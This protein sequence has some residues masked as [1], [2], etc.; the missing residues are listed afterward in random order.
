M[1]VVL[2]I[3]KEL[4]KALQRKDQDIANVMKL[5]RVIKERLQMMRDDECDS[6]L[7][8]VH[9]FFKKCEIDTL[10]MNDLFVERKRS[11]YKGELINLHH[12]WFDILTLLWACNFKN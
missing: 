6:L 11:W 8:L 1:R 9:L 10:N 12:F 5:V 3:A 7:S 4:S 2:A